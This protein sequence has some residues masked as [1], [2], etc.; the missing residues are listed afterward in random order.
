MKEVLRL[1]E[2]IQFVFGVYLFSLLPFTWWW[3]LVLFLAPD[4]AMLGYVFGNR[5]GAFAYN[6]FHHKGM[7]IAVYLLGVYL[8]NDILLLAGVILYAHSA[9]DR[10]LGY[11][12][13]YGTGFNNSH[14]GSI[15]K[16]K[17]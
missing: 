3:F 14:L 12:L 4:L 11:G 17:E 16:K 6:L 7:A 13:K 8:G 2:L 10:I 9:F 5:V 15:G 1:E